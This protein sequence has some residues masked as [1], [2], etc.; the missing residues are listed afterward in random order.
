M[1]RRRPCRCI[2]WNTL[3][4]R[5]PAAPAAAAAAATPRA[6]LGLGDGLRVARN[7]ATLTS[8]ASAVL[9]Q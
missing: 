5:A 1:R 9:A 7:L 4:I 2:L 8:S 6:R 3:E